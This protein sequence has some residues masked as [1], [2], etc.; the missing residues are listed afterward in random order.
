MQILALN[1]SKNKLFLYTL[2]ND[3]MCLK[4]SV[5][6]YHLKGAHQSQFCSSIFLNI[7]SRGKNGPKSVKLVII[8]DYLLDSVILVIKVTKNDTFL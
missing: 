2:K 5:S 8:N 6:I 3:G 7:L 4:S 1:M